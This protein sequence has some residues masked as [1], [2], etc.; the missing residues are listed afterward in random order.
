MAKMDEGRIKKNKY[1]VSEEGNVRRG[2]PLDVLKTDERV[3][4]KTQ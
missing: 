4:M 2:V 3:Y 1:K